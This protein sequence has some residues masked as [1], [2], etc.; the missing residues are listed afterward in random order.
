MLPT[1]LCIYRYIIKR[2]VGMESIADKIATAL[3]VVLSRQFDCVVEVMP[4]RTEGE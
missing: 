1:E 3:S 4:M 2:E